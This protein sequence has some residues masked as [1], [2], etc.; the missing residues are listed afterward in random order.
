MK[1]EIKHVLGSVLFEG[2][3]SCIKEAVVA[4]IKA[5]VSLSGANLRGAD[6]SWA[7]LSWAN[8]YGA[9][10]RE[11]DLRG[12]NIYEANLDRATLDHKTKLTPSQNARLSIVPSD[13]GFIGWKKCNGGIIAKLLIPAS[14]KRSNATSRKCRAE[15]VKVVQLYKDG[16]VFYGEAITDNHGPVT[17]Y[18]V[19]ETVRPNSFDPCRWNE[20]APGIH[21]FIT[22]EEAEVHQ[23]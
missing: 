1:I 23:C 14:A 10:L 19:G 12:A 2:D 22:R 11:A 6:L 16:R 20:C 3:F 7:D 15:F 18:R 4:A 9:D 21:F 13:G 17:I 5:G 8:L